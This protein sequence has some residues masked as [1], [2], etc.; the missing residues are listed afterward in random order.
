MEY[1]GI[2]ASLGFDTK[3]QVLF[4]TLLDV[5]GSITFEAKT[6][7]TLQKNFE[8]AV[9]S[10]LAMCKAQHI[11]ITK[12]LSDCKLYTYE[13][14]GLALGATVVVMAT[15]EALAKILVYNKLTDLGLEM[16]ENPLM[17]ESI[18]PNSVVYAD[19]GDY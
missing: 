13:G 11:P 10:Y 12:E 7:K 5:N 2:K 17:I 8:M 3:N 1:K 4:G 19:D 15:S 9:D 18:R 16:E 14:K 6:T